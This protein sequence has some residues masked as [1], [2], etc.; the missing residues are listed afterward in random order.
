MNSLNQKIE[1]LINV[2]YDKEVKEANV[3]ELYNIIYKVVM[4]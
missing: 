4:L 2:K 1:T 3:L